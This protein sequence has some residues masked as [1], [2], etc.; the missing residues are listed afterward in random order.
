MEKFLRSEL[1]DVVGTAAVGVVGLE[2]HVAEG[3]ADTGLAVLVGLELGEFAVERHRNVGHED[4]LRRFVRVGLLV[5]IQ[6]HL[7]DV[8]IVT[9]GR[10]GLLNL[11]AL[12]VGEPI[13]GA[14]TDLVEC[15]SIDLLVVDG[16]LVV[17]I[18]AIGNADADEASAASV[19]G[20]R[21][22][23]VGVG[24]ER[25]VARTIVLHTSEGA[26]RVDLYAA[27]GLLEV[28]LLA[29]AESVK[30]LE[31]D[32]EVVGQREVGVELVAHIEVVHGVLTQVLGDEADAE[33]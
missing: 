20:Q 9:E 1:D 33:G 31:Q 3:L 14:V 27:E 7:V 11:V 22:F 25:R 4:A 13:A 24:H 23:V 26:A 32:E 29:S 12:V 16:R 19:V 2:A 21:V 10:I 28:R 8:E 18:R 5:D 6:E 15:L 17:E 30:L